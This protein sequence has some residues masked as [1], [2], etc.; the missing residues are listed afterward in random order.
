MRKFLREPLLPAAIAALAVP[1]TAHTTEI[2]KIVP[3]DLAAD[4]LFGQSVSV[5]GL[6]LCVGAAGSDAAATDAGAIYVFVESGGMWTQQAK[7]TASTAAADD[8]LG[9]AI[10]MD[11]DT[12]VASAPFD[13][14]N[15]SNSGSVFVFTR[16]GT[17]WSEQAI[18]QPTGGSAGDWFGRSVAIDGDTVLVGTHFDDD[19]GENAGSVFVF[20]RSGTT[21]TQEAQLNAG[22]A[23]A[24]DQF[25]NGVSLTGDLA[26]VGA[27]GDDDNGVDSGSA[28]HFSRSGTV[29]TEGGKLTATDGEAGDEYGASVSVTDDGGELRVAIGAPGDDDKAVGAGAGYAYKNLSGPWVFEAKHFAPGGRAG[30]DFGRS[31]FVEEY[32]FLFGSPLGD[33]G[34]NPGVPDAGRGHSFGGPPENQEIGAL[35]ALDLEAGAE[36][37]TSCS[38]DAEWI[39]MGAPKDGSMGA[40]YIFWRV[41]PPVNYCTAGTSASGC[42]AQILTNGYP[43]AHEGPPVFFW[44]IGSG[45]EGAKD[46]MFFFGSS[47]RQA[48]SWGSGTS[49]MC[50]LPPRIRTGLQTG[51]GTPGACDGLFTVD[52]NALW[53][54]T[55]PKPA[56]NP[57]AG[58]IL[59]AQLWYRDPFNTSNQT[60]SLSDA[61]EFGVNP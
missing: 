56:K 36:L 13:D 24:G 55:C 31:C 37:G 22:D 12:I 57:G 53:C 33:P 4:D 25:G 42:K 8:K 17:V 9:M 58:A 3:G 45:V 14:D 21:W 23:S 26:L 1:L 50:V 51:T 41:F 49:Y 54:S 34:P 61:V 48:N 7:F 29:W 43:S 15:G 35:T 6:T 32:F 46:G 39:A 52:L 5:S 2:Q 59:Q 11:G 47:G 16:T 27:P 30:D 18:L 38:I 20:T 40:V 10:A 28:Y 60:T 44:L 19:F